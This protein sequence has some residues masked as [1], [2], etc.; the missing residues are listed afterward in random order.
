MVFNTA[1]VMSKGQIILPVDIRRRMRLST[2]DHVVLIYENDRVILMN[3][4]IYAEQLQKSAVGEWEKAGIHSQEDL[5]NLMRDSLIEDEIYSFGGY[6]WRILDVQDGKVLLLSEYLLETRAYHESEV[7]ITWANS[8][9]RQYLNSEFYNRFSAE[10]KA[11]I[12]ET[13]VLNNDN[14]WYDT[15]GGYSTFDKV[16]LLSVEEVVE[17]FGD[18][19][20]LKNRPRG[21]SYIDDK[22]NNARIAK[23]LGGEVYWWLLRSS[24]YKST[25]AASVSS[26]GILDVL[27]DG[28]YHSDGYIR[29][30]LWLNL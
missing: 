5:D 13:R 16:F 7:N 12:A 10:E 30:A 8:T 11:R 9:L 26:F 29:P 21:K 22:Y 28:V 3:P 6:D 23:C 17:Y 1:K 4:A 2:G 20:Q 18:S 24:G 19:G 14:P 27:G 25:Y 15:K